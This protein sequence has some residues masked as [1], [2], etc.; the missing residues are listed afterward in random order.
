MRDAADMLLFLIIRTCLLTYRRIL[1]VTRRLLFNLNLNYASQDHVFKMLGKIHCVQSKPQKRRYRPA[2]CC[3]FVH[4]NGFGTRYLPCNQVQCILEDANT[5]TFVHIMY[6]VTFLFQGQLLGGWFEAA[7]FVVGV[8]V[9]VLQLWQG[10]GS[11]SSAKETALGLV[12]KD[13]DD[14]IGKCTVST[15]GE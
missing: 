12:E 13:R 4:K 5:T 7:L 9:V 15:R 3:F 1:R 10:A 6:L 11:R 2:C 14:M 8:A